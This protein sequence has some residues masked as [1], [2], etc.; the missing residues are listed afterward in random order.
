[1]PSSDSRFGSLSKWYID[2][3]PGAAHSWPISVHIWFNFKVNLSNFLPC[4][5]L[6]G[7]TGG[8]PLKQPYS[9]FRGGLQ[10]GRPVAI[11]CLFRHP[12]PYTIPASVS[13][14]IRIRHGQFVPGRNRKSKS[15]RFAIWAPPNEPKKINKGL[16]VGR[17][18]G[19]I[20][21]LKKKP[22]TKSLGLL[23]SYKR[24]GQK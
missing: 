2:A 24:N 21:K 6:L 20:S 9:R 11:F 17:M 13:S 15:A 5:T 4:P 22:I 18:Y 19:P 3:N 8:P 23:Y 10:G 7:P 12:M 14:M 1:V 16:Q